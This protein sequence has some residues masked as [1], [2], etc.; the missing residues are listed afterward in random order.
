MIGIQSDELDVQIYPAATD[1]LG[2]T[3]WEA[4]C[5]QGQL[6][7]ATVQLERAFMPAW[8]DTS[9]GTVVL[10][11][12]RVSDLSVCRTMIELKVRSHLE[13]LNIEM[14]RRLWQPQCNHNFGD[15]MCGY[16]RV[17]GLNAD[18]TP[19]G[20]G[21]V[22]FA[23]GAGSTSSVIEGWTGS[24]LYYL[25]TLIGVTGANTGQRRTIYGYSAT[26]LS[27]KLAF[28]STPA[29]GDEFQALPGCDRTL[30]T[31]G[32]V[33]RNSRVTS[34][35]YNPANAE[36]FGG[37]PFIP[38]PENAHLTA[39]P[40]RAGVVAEAL[41]WIG[42]PYRAAQRVKGRDGGVDCLT[43][44]VEVFGRCGFDTSYYRAR[45]RSTRRIGTCTATTSAIWAASSNMRARYRR[46][47]EPGDIALFRFGRC[48]AHGGI[49]T[50]W[51]MI[52]HAWNG[53]GVLPA[54]ATQALLGGRPRRFF[55]PF[56]HACGL[57]GAPSLP[58]RRPGAP[59]S[60]AG[61]AR[62]RPG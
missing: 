46:P 8:G 9:P 39:L 18:G 43:F 37:F 23:C 13:L 38:P 29:P 20:V 51:P 32:N 7:G 61:R 40:A 16:N 57:S 44:V 6:D 22:N 30:L 3:S 55:S 27:L 36:T 21:A 34:T 52:V 59:L 2:G 54:D 42:T 5:W 24:G 48:F 60:P 41:S 58:P 10:F 49:V 62:A 33:Y 17:L 50:R 47:P 35:G 11:A 56:T 15:A 26:T 19:T 1:L 12:G 28:L 53:A 45:S 31:C 14:P 4:A 25:G